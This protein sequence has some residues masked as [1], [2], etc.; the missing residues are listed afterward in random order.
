VK[1]AFVALVEKQCDLVFTEVDHDNSGALDSAELHV[2]ILL[3]Y[4]R[5]NQ[6]MGSMALKVPRAREV[7]ELLAEASSDSRRRGELSREEFRAM[8]V[9]IFVPRVAARATAH[10]MTRKLLV[11]A[12]AAAL[13][14]VMAEM[15]FGKTLAKAVKS[16]KHKGIRGFFEKQVKGAVTKKVLSDLGPAFGPLINLQLAGI[17]ADK[18]QVEAG[19]MHLLGGNGFNGRGPLAQLQVAR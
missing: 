10:L 15:G 4:G 17:A 2:A 5:L 8:F 11:P 18:L 13:N 1:E 16:A 6:V 14:V 3:V 19:L 7:K 9:N 12:A